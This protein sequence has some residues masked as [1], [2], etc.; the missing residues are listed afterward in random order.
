[1]STYAMPTR[2]AGNGVGDPKKVTETNSPLKAKPLITSDNWSI[3]GELIRLWLWR[4]LDE[5]ILVPGCD[6]C[7]VNRDSGLLVR[8]AESHAN[9]V[10]RHDLRHTCGGRV[11][12]VVPLKA[13]EGR[14][15]IPKR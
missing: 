6:L 5:N 2:G 7:V 12:P 10:A 13:A 11:I 1:M 4:C 9:A 8:L 14:E 3:P 15:H